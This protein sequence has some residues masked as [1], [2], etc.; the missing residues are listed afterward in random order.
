MLMTKYQQFPNR[1]QKRSD[2]NQAFIGTVP[3]KNPKFP[4][5]EIGQGNDARRT[6]VRA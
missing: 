5:K 6:L 4:E 1:L 2:A 3:D